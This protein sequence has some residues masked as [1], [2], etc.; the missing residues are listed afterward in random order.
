MIAAASEPASRG[1]CPTP[2]YGGSIIWDHYDVGIP[3]FS[4]LWFLADQD[5]EVHANFDAGSNGSP[6][7][8]GTYIAGEEIDLWTSSSMLVGSVLAANQC[9]NDSGPLT[10]DA[11]CHPGAGDLVPA[12]LGHAVL[13]HRLHDPLARILSLSPNH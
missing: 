7:I 5:L 12:E 9:P 3:N 13:E 6:P 2:R 11:Q 4:D 1:N 8:A 10:S